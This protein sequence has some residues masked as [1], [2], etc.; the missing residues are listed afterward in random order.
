LQ[1]A[2]K[3]PRL[4]FTNIIA[5]NAQTPFRPWSNHVAFDFKFSLLGL[6]VQGDVGGWTGYTDRFG[7]HHWYPK[8]PP[9]T[10]PTEAQIFYRNRWSAGAALW[11]ALTP[12][13]QQAYSAVCRKLSLMLTGPSL[14]M[15][16]YCRNNLELIK[17]LEQQS[18][19]S[20]EAPPPPE[21]P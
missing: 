15:T 8:S 1:L 7:R 2:T 5:S 20:L 17:T 13:Q 6:L 9:L 12:Q 10:P 11:R 3:R 19:I 18:G 14:Y 4:T 21:L 16:L